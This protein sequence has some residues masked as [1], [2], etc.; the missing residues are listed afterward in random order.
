MVH[1]SQARIWHTRGCAQL[2]PL[3][4]SEVSLCGICSIAPRPEVRISP[5][6]SCCAATHRLGPGPRH[7]TT[8]RRDHS[9]RSNH[10]PQPRLGPDQQHRL[11]RRHRLHPLHPLHRPALARTPHDQRQRHHRQRAQLH[12]RPQTP[13]LPSTASIPTPP[14]SPATATSPSTTPPTATYGDNSFVYS[15]GGGAEFN[16]T[17][18]VGAAPRLHPAALEPRPQTLT[19]MTFGVGVAYSIPFHTRPRAAKPAA[20]NRAVAA[21][22][23]RQPHLY[24]NLR[25]RPGGCY[26]R[27]L[28]DPTVER[29]QSKLKASAV[30]GTDRDTS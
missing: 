10:P 20:F 13:D 25:R 24:Q 29:I 28:G 1:G 16:V 14:S 12:R 6:S 15:L 4:I 3:T 9:L 23:A 5:R 18:P 19:P 2:S 7:R 11:H 22:A 8:R 26:A 27:R 30:P 17:S 21:S